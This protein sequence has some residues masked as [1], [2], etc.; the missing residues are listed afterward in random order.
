MGYV[1]R[2]LSRAAQ[3]ESATTGE[4]KG[5]VIVDD[6]YGTKVGYKRGGAKHKSNDS[7]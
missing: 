7:G 1:P 5:S 2:T 6:G 3:R 4:R